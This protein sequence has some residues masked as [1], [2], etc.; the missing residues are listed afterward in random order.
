MEKPKLYCPYC[1]LEL[2]ENGRH[3]ND[4]KAWLLFGC[5]YNAAYDPK[6]PVSELVIKKIELKQATGKRKEL[7]K[8][9]RSL[10]ARINELESYI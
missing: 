2:G 3:K 4:E 10:N 6:S 5:E 7:N 8:T 1:S 9:V